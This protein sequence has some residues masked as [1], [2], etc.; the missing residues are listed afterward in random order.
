[1]RSIDVTSIRAALAAALALSLTA[2]LTGCG[3]AGNQ[4]PEAPQ[5]AQPPSGESWAAAIGEVDIGQQNF[6]CSGV[7]V[8]PNVIV[9]ASHCLTV[10][11][12]NARPL[13]FSP[14]YGSGANL[15]TSNGVA[16]KLGAQV[17]AGSIR[18]EDVPNDWAV[19][20]MTILR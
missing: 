13:V 16:L 10:A 19:V 5:A 2:L 17:S 8:A 11:A 7:L 9:T 1:M 18:N 6:H 15:P 14:G 3:T 12:Q 4:R 20:N